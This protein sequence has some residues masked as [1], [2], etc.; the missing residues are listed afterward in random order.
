MTTITSSEITADNTSLAV[1][2]GQAVV[3]ALA[4]DDAVM[5]DHDGSDLDESDISE[6]TSYLSRRGVSCR[7]DHDIGCTVARR[8]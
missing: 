6:M 5:L 3:A 4:S 8:S 7:Y 1:A 2:V